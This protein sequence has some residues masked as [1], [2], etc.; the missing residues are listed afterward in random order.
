MKNVFFA[1][2][3]L[4]A[5]AAGAQGQSLVLADGGLQCPDGTVQSTAA[6]KGFA[7]VED[8]GQKLCWDQAGNSVSCPLTFQDGDSQ[9][10]VDWPSPRFSSN[11]DGTITDN[12]TGLIWLQDA[13]CFGQKTWQ[14]ALDAVVGLALGLQACQNY[15]AGQINLAW[16]LPNI[17]EL[18]SLIDDGQWNPALPVGHLF[19][20][21]QSWWYWT[22]SSY[23]ASPFAA[24]AVTFTDGSFTNPLKD[25]TIWVLPVRGGQ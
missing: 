15:P 11:L 14:G 7:P 2:G 22:S 25:N 24:W 13:E 5:I 20:D 17:K 9:A 4:V 3:V 6:A 8:T 10:G 21:V 18:Q 12:L 19:I 1:L 16:R 23:V